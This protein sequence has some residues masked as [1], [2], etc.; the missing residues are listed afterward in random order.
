MKQ[1]F[2]V[3]SID[4]LNK[5]RE[6]ATSTKNFNTICADRCCCCFD[7]PPPFPKHQPHERYHW[8][9]VL[10]VKY[11]AFCYFRCTIKLNLLVQ[12]FSAFFPIDKSSVCCL[13]QCMRSVHIMPCA[14][15]SR[16]FP[17]LSYGF[18]RADCISVVVVVVLLPFI[19]LIHGCIVLSQLQ[20]AL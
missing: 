8:I 9:G 14:F 15:V 7:V 5:N 19:N 17:F 2:C 11:L 12:L 13:L 3:W 20:F 6:S 16:L 10:W 4:M 18:S 1:P